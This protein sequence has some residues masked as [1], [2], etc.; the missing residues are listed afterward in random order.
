MK[1]T[2]KKSISI[3]GIC[4]IL[5]TILIGV[6]A[7]HAQT[8]TYRRDIKLPP[9]Y[10]LVNNLP[11]ND[12]GLGA[13]DLHMGT[14]STNSG[15]GSV[16]KSRILVFFK[17][18][19]RMYEKGDGTAY[20]GPRLVST[21]QWN[22]GSV[23][24]RHVNTNSNFYPEYETW[25]GA[26]GASAPR[27][28]LVNP[29]GQQ[30]KSW[31]TGSTPYSAISFGGNSTSIV[32][33]RYRTGDSSM[34]SINHNTGEVT[35]FHGDVLEETGKRLGGLLALAYGADNNLHLLDYDNRRILTFDT[36]VNDGGT[37]GAL[38]GTFDLDPTKEAIN[39]MTVD[40][41]GNFYIGDGEGG[42][43]MYG[44]DG[45]WKQGF[46]ATFVPDPNAI[47]NVAQQGCDPVERPGYV[48]YMNY[49]ASGL[50]D[51]N[52]TLDIRDG[53]GYRQYNIIG[54]VL[55]EE[56]IGD[57]IERV[58]SFHLQRGI[59]NALLAKLN[60][61]LAALAEGD[62]AKVRESIESFIN[63]VQAQSGKKITTEQAENLIEAANEIYEAMQ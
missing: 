7:A 29:G 45:R 58:Q 25:I 35:L 20:F 51:G 36:G 3:S 41:A 15:P 44:R 23:A 26:M 28:I 46:H 27:Y 40:L 14:T 50:D 34:H 55:P 60:S 38:L 49:Y 30:A 43:D 57:L 11:L 37:R 19:Y 61:A 32:A 16:W 59:E 6:G 54:A 10:P 1:N 13:T 56:L 47:C 39:A 31:E 9:S 52:G 63:Q 33:G 12:S 18:Y 53:T 5:L 24:E 62:T 8:V 21:A 2:N 42:F 48:P 22:N 4:L 17:A